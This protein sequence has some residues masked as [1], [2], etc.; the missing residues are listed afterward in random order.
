MKLSNEKVSLYRKT[1]QHQLKQIEN[2]AFKCA[3]TDQLVRGTPGEVFRS[4]GKAAC[5]CAQDPEYRH[6][7]YQVIQVYVDGKQK[8]VALR[9][10]EK[11]LW[12][13]VQN[14]QKQMRYL[15]TLRQELLALEELVKN[16]I[17]QRINQKALLCRKK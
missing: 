9:K 14:Y 3:H 16:M 8:Q 5:R 13:Q 11:I 4:C 7:P 15:A 2:L 6:G 1:L 10:S 12:A 17:E